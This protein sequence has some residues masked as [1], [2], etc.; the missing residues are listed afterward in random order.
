MES[1]V[2]RDSLLYVAGQLDLTMGGVELENSESLTTR[3]RSLYYSVY[4]EAGGKSALG[5]LFDGPDPLDCYRRASSIVPQQALALT[6]SEL[7]HQ[8]SIAVVT[9]WLSGNSGD[10]RNTADRQF[11]TE[12][13]EQILTRAPTD[14][15]LEICLRTLQT[16]VSV[17]STTDALEQQ[18]LAYQS[19]V[20]VLLN[21]NDF[22][23]TR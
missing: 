6:N 2:V 17:S 13:F 4:P 15:E 16:Q 21:H 9:S 5:E 8:M 3:R 23:T 12:M 22:L 10:D 11:V 14:V 7:V 1:E 18:R 19:L 20:R